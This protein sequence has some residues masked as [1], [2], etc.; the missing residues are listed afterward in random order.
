MAL[1]CSEGQRGGAPR[2]IGEK[3]GWGGTADVQPQR[4]GQLRWRGAQ[5]KEET[6]A[7]VGGA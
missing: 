6:V 3:R 4:F 7:D 5:G 1:G 2:I